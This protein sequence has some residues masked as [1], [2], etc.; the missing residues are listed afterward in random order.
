MKSEVFQ[1][2]SEFFE[3]DF[4]EVISLERKN[5]K[6]N[7]KSFQEKIDKIISQENLAPNEKSATNNQWVSTGVDIFDNREHR[8]GPGEESL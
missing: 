2:K 8:D 7:K 1:Y 3:N 6:T 5:K 4:I